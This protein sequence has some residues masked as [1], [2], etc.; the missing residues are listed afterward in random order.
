[1][2]D[3]GETAAIV[4][5]MRALADRPRWDRDDD[6]P[7]PKPGDRDPEPEAIGRPRYPTAQGAP[8]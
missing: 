3:P 4:E 8:L 5:L 7:Q 2:L 6:A 1:V